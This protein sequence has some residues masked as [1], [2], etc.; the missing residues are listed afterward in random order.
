MKEEKGSGQHDL[1][2]GKLSDVRVFAKKLRDFGKHLVP[3]SPRRAVYWGLLLAVAVVGVLLTVAIG[4]QFSDSGTSLLAS[5]ST[6]TLYVILALA[7]VLLLA[8][9]GMLFYLFKTRHT[10]FG[11][12]LTEG[13]PAESGKEEGGG[14]KG[15]KA[16]GT[17]FD[18][19]TRIDRD[20]EKYRREKYDEAVSLQELCERFRAYAAGNLR[21]YYDASDI[22]RFIA[23]LLVSHIMIL[24]GMS[25]TG[26]TSLAYAFGEFLDNPS[27]V[28]PVQP[29][30]KERTDLIGYYNEFT[31][32]FNETDLLKKMYEANYSEDIY[33]T[34]LDEMNIA[35]VEYYFAEFLSLLELPDAEEREL[36][37]VSD[38]WQSDPKQLRGGHIKLPENMWFIGTAN[39]D[40]STFAISDKVYD[41]AMIMDLD[42]KA[43]P[44]DAEGGE[45]LHL[46]WERFC[47]LGEEAQEE[48]EITHRN[49]KR[50]EEM[51][52][53]MKEHFRITFGNRIMKQIKAYVPIYIG[54]GGEELEALDDILAKKVMRKLG[55]QNPVYLRNQADKFCRKIDEL[56]GEESMQQC[57]AVIQR[58]KM[59]A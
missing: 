23:G 48:Y 39:N 40:D 24:Q 38:E 42:R 1:R 43:E 41:R 30:W 50:L 55:M 13:A 58:L 2:E 44:W 11:T 25:G 51:D 28:V 56:F 29:M 37:V 35:R 15:K 47:E 59:N 26:K 18:G 46:R 36:T 5:V 12:A 52:R 9:A 31:K 7:I 49:L 54:C 22:R 14:K 45:K 4:V 10:P 32:R 6:G 16:T 53:F 20:R 33:I 3:R 57:K 21:L 34:V 27:T 8:L 17:R 19:L